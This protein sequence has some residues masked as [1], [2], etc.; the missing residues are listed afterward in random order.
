MWRT[1]SSTCSRTN[2]SAAPRCGSMPAALREASDLAPHPNRAR[3]RTDGGRVKRDVRDASHASSDSA[4]APGAVHV[5]TDRCPVA[6]VGGRVSGRPVRAA[7]AQGARGHA[8]V[9]RLLAIETATRPLYAGGDG[10]NL[11][12]REGRIR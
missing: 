10:P 1:R 9:S 12:A 4:D 3:A 11:R 5:E 2:P 7:E 8:L 6:L